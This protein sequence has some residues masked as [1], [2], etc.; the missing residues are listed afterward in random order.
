M[1]RV[2]LVSVA[3]VLVVFFSGLTAASAGEDT[4]PHFEFTISI[5]SPDGDDEVRVEGSYTCAGGDPRIHTVAEETPLKFS[6][7]G[8]FAIGAFRSLDKERRIEVE[9]VKL[10]D[11][12]RLHTTQVKD[13]GVAFG[14]GLTSPN[15]HFVASYVPGKAADAAAAEPAVSADAGLRAGDR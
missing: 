14:M 11:G 8:R 2:G 10:R 4:Q 1:R 15:Q 13:V 12:N 7:R 3:T 9:L 5:T 6:C